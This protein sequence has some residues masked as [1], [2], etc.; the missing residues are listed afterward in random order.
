MT[1]DTI[2]FNRDGQIAIITLN[3]PKSMNA[4]N[5]DLSHPGFL[6]AVTHLFC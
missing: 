1:F 5:T 2:Y 6:A 4:I 3:R